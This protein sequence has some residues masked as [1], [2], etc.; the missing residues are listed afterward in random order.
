MKEIII[1][2]LVI[3]GGMLT[4]CFA[5]CPTTD[6]SLP[7]SACRDERMETMNLSASGD[8]SWD[9]CAGD[10]GG[11]PTA[12]SGWTIPGVNGRPGIDLAFDGKW[13]AFVTGTFSG[14]LYRMEFDN[15]LGTNPTS[16][17]NLASL[18][19]SLNQ[20]GQIKIIKEGGQWYG[21]LHNTSG[22]LLKLTFGSTL[23][24][25]PAVSSLISGIGYI[26]SGLAVG[27]DEVHGY[28]AALTDANNQAVLIRLGFT[29]TTPD[30]VA[31]VVRSATVP[32]P[33]NLGDIDLINVCGT[34]YGF[35]DNLGNGNIYR[36]DFGSSLFS[37]PAITQLTT[38]TSSNP[39]RLRLVR[40]G[41]EYFI[42]VLSL[43]GS[44]TKGALGTSIT[45]SPVMSNE[46]TLGV[47][48]SSMYALGMTKENSI[49]T[50][51]GVN[52]S[53]GQF[54]RINYNNSCSA[55]PM[56]SALAA[57]TVI[58]STAGTYLVTLENSTATGVGAKS[59]AITVS[60]NQSP[61]ITVSASGSCAA[62]PVQFTSSNVS[63]DLV[64]YAW[65]FGDSQVSSSAD[66]VHIY[67]NPGLYS[68][69]LTV[70]ATNGCKNT[71]IHPLDIFLAPVA[72]F[73]LPVVSP[74]CTNSNYSFTNT[75]GYAPAS[76]PT[77][78][79]K[80]NGQPVGNQEDLDITFSDPG[81]QEIRLKASIPGCDS[82]IAKSI[83][84]A[85]VGPDII[86]DAA[87]DCAL[88]SVPFVN[89][90]TGADAGYSW[91]FGDGSPASTVAQPAH[92]Y[93]APGNYTVT[94]TASNVAGCNNFATQ[95][96][97]IFS[98]PQPD[99]SV[100]AP[101]FSCSSSS[102]LFQNLT[103]PPADSN[104]SAWLWSFGDPGSNTSAIQEPSFVY[105]AGG[106][107]SV[108][109]TATSDAGC[110]NTLTKPVTIG[111]SPV[112]NFVLG[113]ACVD[114]PT[115]FS[116]I[117]SGGVQ[118]RV[119]QIGTSTFSSVNPTYTYTTPGNYTATLT[120]ASANGCTNMVSKPVNV[121]VPPTLTLQV[122]NP[123]ED[124]PAVFTLVDATVP[125]ASDPANNW[126]WN[127]GGTLV[128]GNPATAVVSLAAS[129][130][131]SV[132]T[133]H[134]SGCSYTQFYPTT[135]HPTPVA[136][137]Q[138][139]PDRGDAPLTVQFQNLS[140]GAT[141]Y[142]WVFNDK[143]PVTST[144][145]SPVY[146]FLELG[147]YSAQLTATNTDGC[148][149]SISM[150]IQ[151]LIPEIDLEVTS[152]SLF[153][154][155]AT[156]K[157]K[158]SLTLLNKSN[159][160]VV[161]VE[162]ILLLSDRANVSEAL[163]VNLSPGASVTKTLTAVVDPAQFVD[164]FV[165]VEVASEKDLTPGNNKS[166]INFS[167]E[168][169]IFDPY[170]NPSTGP[171]QVDWISDQAGLAYVTIVNSQGRT[172]YYWETPSQPGLNRSLHDLSFLAAGIYFV[173][174]RTS[175]S[176]ETRRIVRL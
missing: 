165:C 75:T 27:R 110:V 77:W 14:T 124:Q 134:A 119:W 149:D 52:Q 59:S 83:P 141:Q 167:D 7:S 161:V 125:P 22:E 29:L 12:D 10:F 97:S 17:V 147:D 33:N 37:G 86:F 55:S 41:E 87:D 113:P 8:Y 9:F 39:G 62:A 157:L 32:N 16:I 128:S 123:C 31:D 70:T 69:K 92:V 35:A 166:C 79:W 142:R 26:N 72:D 152:F 65:D 68:S 15:G 2:G 80:L 61:D 30:P 112:A 102:T 139:L 51:L 94:L 44:F 151:V 13:Y 109:L 101:P 85:L 23:S 117:S 66:P 4:P 103:P 163:T 90:T 36:L 176:V 148:S 96:I 127:I 150:P 115:Q 130:P 118:S 24:N 50:I 106:T 171:V 43:D 81:P 156:G 107:Y 164:P 21:L 93:T 120:V 135:I 144:D 11:S 170:P 168:D 159:I 160:P 89:T 136:D 49:W 20:P 67:A 140:S 99:F 116:D 104:I 122:E 64:G 137:F 34:W 114:A 173:T 95:N 146:T 57:P 88:S 56:V 132:I 28:V 60:P 74:I 105:S 1:L 84:S 25:V 111:T 19:G 162:V 42:F 78:E 175:T 40:E 48:T 169:Y 5:Q 58:Y 18:S 6:F 155:P 63:G 138:A 158:P 145:T 108:S 82:E 98:V 129:T 53:N 121:P 54:Y 126:Q 172:E 46:G 153:P 38:L 45:G 3:A 91:D 76:S 174:V 71:A 47:L 100:A 133:A 143:I 131:V 73:S 154:D